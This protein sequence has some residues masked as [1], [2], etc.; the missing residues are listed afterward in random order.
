MSISIAQFIEAKPKELRIGQWFVLC[1]CKPFDN[2]WEYKIDELWNKDG[3][4]AM[5]LIKELMNLWQWDN[6][7]DIKG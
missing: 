1:Y 3:Y 4:I 7:P 2:R 5:V 6:L